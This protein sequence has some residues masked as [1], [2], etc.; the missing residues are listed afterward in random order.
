[1]NNHSHPLDHFREQVKPAV[2][3]KIEEFVLLGYDRVSEEEIWKYLTM[4][5]WKRNSEGKMLHQ[6][7][8]DILTLRICEF[9]NFATVEAYKSP[10][11]FSTD[12]VEALKELL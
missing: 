11:W 8:N 4:K 5:K 10:D 6:V 12:G 7:V 9:M 1:M 3:S 2:I